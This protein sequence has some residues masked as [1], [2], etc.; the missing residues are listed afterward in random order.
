MGMHDLDD[1][2]DHPQRNERRS[3]LHCTALGCFPVSAVSAQTD[4]GQ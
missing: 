2:N 4:L 3:L 1:Y